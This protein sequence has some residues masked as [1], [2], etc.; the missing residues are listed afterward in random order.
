MKLKFFLLFSCCLIATVTFGQSNA[1]NS[2]G[3]TAGLG[4][5]QTSI[6]VD[7]FHNWR[8]GKYKKFEVGLGVR[9]TSYFGTDQNYLSAPANLANDTE[10]TDTVLFAAP[11]VNAFNLAINLGYQII[12]KLKAG[13]NI[14]ALGFSFGGN[15]S[16]SYQ[17]NNQSNTT[18][19]KPTSFNALLV[20]NNDLGTLN[21]EFYLRYAVKENWNLKLAYQFLFTEYTTDTPVQQNPELNDRFRNKSSLISFGISRNF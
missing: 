9:Y 16:G 15:K 4:K 12:P 21:S 20:G 11:Q 18:S 7:F 13:F 8:L 5:D 6:S 3:F 17:I 19:A 10:N 2:V 1:Y 14:D